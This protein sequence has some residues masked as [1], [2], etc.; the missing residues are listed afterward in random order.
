MRVSGTE[1]DDLWSPGAKVI[2]VFITRQGGS[3]VN[4]LSPSL[5]GNNPCFTPYL[6]TVMNTFA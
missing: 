1:R 5:L 4:Q 3:L 6:N 2:S